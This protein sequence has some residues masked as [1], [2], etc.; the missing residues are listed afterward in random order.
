MQGL[1]CARRVFVG[2]LLNFESPAG[3]GARCRSFGT[4]K[5]PGVGV[6]FP[7]L[8]WSVD[9][10]EAR[11]HEMWMEVGAEERAS[12]RRLMTFFWGVYVSGLISR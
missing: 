11:A 7:F 6:R 9:L 10:P 8:A 3:F 1:Q 12:G 5:F 4:R 2:G